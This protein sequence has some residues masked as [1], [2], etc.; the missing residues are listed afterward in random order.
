MSHQD[1]DYRPC[2]TRYRDTAYFLEDQLRCS[3]AI[4]DFRAVRSFIEDVRAQHLS[5]KLKPAPAPVRIDPPK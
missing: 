2:D 5:P 1:P 3:E 4:E